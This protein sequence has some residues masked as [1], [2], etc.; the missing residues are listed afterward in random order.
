MEFVQLTAGD[1]AE[2]KNL[3]WSVFTGA[4]WYDDW[5]DA[6]QLGC[7]I[8]EL[9]AAP[10]S[11]T[12]GLRDGGELIALSMGH[13]RHWYQGT[14]YYIDE[15]CVRTDRQGQGAGRAL[16]AGIED[17]LVRQ[18]MRAIFLLTERTV[19]AYHFYQKLGFTELRDNAAF[20]KWVK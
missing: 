9:I 8:R 2:I 1:E 5:S 12:Y 15:L 16:V 18:G 6:N 3:F 4:P 7:Y 17:D 13:I 20:A 14:E 10:N 11:L 19:P